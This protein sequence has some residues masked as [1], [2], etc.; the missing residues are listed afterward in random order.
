MNKKMKKSM[1]FILS[2]MTS[3]FYISSCSDTKIK[4]YEK[5]K[6]LE[7]MD[8]LSNQLSYVKYLMDEV[9][10]QDIAERRDYVESELTLIRLKA[11]SSDIPQEYIHSLEEFRALFKIYK[12]GLTNYKKIVM[13]YEELNTQVATLKQSV[14]SEEYAKEDFKK[15][16]ADEKKDVDRLVEYA[17]I[18]LKPILETESLFERRMEE[19]RNITMKLRAKAE[20]GS[21]NT[22]E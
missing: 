2:V 20:K 1:L 7:L 22:T 10:M 11:D 3:F 17:E 18:Y 13:E 5:E 21:D 15:Y 14:Q 8:S 12:A 4:A 16:Y 9:D 19:V 6:S